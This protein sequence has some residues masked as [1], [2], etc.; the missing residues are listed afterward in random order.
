MEINPYQSP[1]VADLPEEQALGDE[2]IRQLLVEIRDG[3][4]EL[5]QLQRDALMR[6]QTMRRM[7]LPMMVL[8]FVAMLLPVGMMIFTT[9][10]RPRPAAPLP[11]AV[12]VR[13]A[14]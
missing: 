10:N 1:R 2:S 5:L 9:L 7:S 14:P 3:Q 4:R 12:P 6:T 11:R 13:P 8:A